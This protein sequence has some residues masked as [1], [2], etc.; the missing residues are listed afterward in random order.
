MFAAPDTFQNLAGR[1]VVLRLRIARD[2]AGRRRSVVTNEVRY[3]YLEDRNGTTFY[4]RIPDFALYDFGEVSARISHV[5]F[6]GTVYLKNVRLRK[7][8]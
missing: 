3:A 5:G 6:D 7:A 1:R 4:A 2:E 8:R